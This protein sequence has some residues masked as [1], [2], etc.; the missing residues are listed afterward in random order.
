MKP[1]FQ[2]ISSEKKQRIIQSCI[3]EFG[4]QGYDHC[5]LDH[6]IKNA[7]ISKGGLYEYINS[8]EDLF[9]FIV[10]YCFN[11]LY[12][13]I[14]SRLA[15][16]KSTMPADILERFRL[17]SGIAIDFYLDHIEIITFIVKSYYLSD[18]ALLKNVQKIFMERFSRIFDFDQDKTMKDNEQ[19]IDL[20]QWLL[21]KTRNDF[22]WQFNSGKSKDT[23]KLSYLKEWEFYFSVLQSGIYKR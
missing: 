6:I 14:E 18:P 9:L 10:S 19:I 11:E 20:L 8:K 21:I 12:N 4:A 1:A 3:V 2:N 15:Q 22:L 17:V 7:G 5:S 16:L 23:L 13:F